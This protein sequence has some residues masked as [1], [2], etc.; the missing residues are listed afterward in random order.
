MTD[1][2]V[3]DASVAA[4]L[5]FR[6]DLSAEAATAVRLAEAIIAPELL[7]IEL[8]SVASKRVR[9]G[10]SPIGPARSAVGSVGELL[11]EVASMVDL[12]PRAFALAV[13][14]GFSAYDATYLAL[15]EARGLRVL[16]ADVRLVTLARKV[17]LDTLV[18][19]L[20]NGTGEGTDRVRP[21][22]RGF[23]T[24]IAMC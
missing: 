9:R 16:T 3:L 1:S 2:I 4:K 21:R 8:A 6:E 13:E 15:A 12:T 10:T 19:Q 20:G 11:D 18:L 17:G 5:Y 24:S 22:R 7:L 14:H 23:R